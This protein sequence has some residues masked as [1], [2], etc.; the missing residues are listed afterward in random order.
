METLNYSEKAWEGNEHHIDDLILNSQIEEHPYV[1]PEP[2]TLEKIQKKIVLDFFNLREYPFG[3]S[4]NLSFLYNSNNH[5]EALLKMLMSVENDISFGLIY[6]KSGTGKTILSQA[7]LQKLTVTR[8]KPVLIPVTPGMSKLAFLKTML[9]EFDVDTAKLPRQ[10]HQLIQ[11]VSD[12][13]LKFHQ[14]EIKPI[15]LIDESHFLSV[16]ALH[17]LRTLSNLESSNKK[18][19]TYILFAEERFLKRLSNPSYESLRNRMY[20]QINLKSLTEEECRYYIQHRLNVSGTRKSDFFSEKEHKSIYKRSKGIP[21][22]INKECT[23]IMVDKF[24][25]MRNG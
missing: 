9:R 22:S 20:L 6:G 18:L 17:L 21:R 3:D 12:C 10:T 8:F 7:L 19:I 1:N 25:A 16:E 11:L 2:S 13:I 23:N 5:E 24:L 14:S 4:L 15:V